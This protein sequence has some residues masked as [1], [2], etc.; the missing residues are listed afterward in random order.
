MVNFT[1]VILKYSI[2]E[3]VINFE[4]KWIDLFKPEYN[5]NPTAGISKGYNHSEKSIEKIRNP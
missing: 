3:D 2:S 5:I 4:Q 1:L